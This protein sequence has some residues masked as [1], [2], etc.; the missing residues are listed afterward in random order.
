[1][2]GAAPP[3]VSF[4]TDGVRRGFFAAQVLA[5]GVVFYALVFGV[6]ASE[7]GLTSLQAMLM[8]AVVYS[9]S[10]QL[11]TL[12]GWTGAALI[13]PLVVTILVLNARYVL[14]GAAIYPWLSQASRGQAYGTLFF[15]GD[16]S[17]AMAMRE[18][19]AGYRD[20]GY[21]LG[22]GV[23]MFVPWVLGTL[24]GHLLARQVPH[25]ATFGLD[26]VLVA[27][28]A[29]IGLQM[30]RGRTDLWPAAAAA[31][32]ALVC[33]RLLPGGWYIVAAGLAGGTVG[34]W[35]HGR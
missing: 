26:F 28:A 31:L 17:W 10:A 22:S 4:T 14:Y 13:T 5:P 23:A 9:G 33:H 12:Q 18:Y 6:V 27:F 19:E 15:L 20:A 32:A 11:A 8:S 1:M 21:V 24:A 2:S 30:W 16:G 34:A 25:P 29:V 7:R 35:R 3:P